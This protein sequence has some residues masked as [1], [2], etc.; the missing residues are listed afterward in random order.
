MFLV[1]LIA[2]IFLAVGK[3]IQ[4]VKWRRKT[5]KIFSKLPGPIERHWLWG[6]YGNMPEDQ[7][8]RCDA[9]IDMCRTHSKETGFMRV[10]GILWTPIIVCCHPSSVRQILRSSEPKPMN[11]TAGYKT[12]MDWLGPG[13][14][15]TNG[16][17]WARKRRLLTKNFH[18]TN[19]KTYVTSCNESATEYLTKLSMFADQKQEFDVYLH[20]KLCML[21]IVL[22]SLV[23]CKKNVQF[24]EQG[25][26][27]VQKV[28]ELTE[29][30]ATR[31]RT[32]LI[33][34]SFLFYQ[35]EMGHTFKR[36][37]E[38]LH[39]FSESIIEERLADYERRSP[40]FDGNTPD[41]LDTLLT[42]RDENGARLPLLDIRHEVD[43]L[44]IG[45]DTTSTS[46]SWIL[47]MLAEHPEIQERCR[48]EL[49]NVLGDRDEVEWADLPNLEYLTMCIKEGL[50]L[51]PTIPFVA[52][53]TTKDF[54][55][56][57]VTVPA[58][59]MIAI[60]IWMLHHNENVWGPDHWEFKPERFSKENCSTMD[61][62]TFVP[63][64]AGP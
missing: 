39:A 27:Y 57:G 30:N 7:N 1:L 19:I 54:E 4:F 22:R 25:K 32:P 36:N 14:L 23:S 41:V 15:L 9:L 16:D 17:I 59:T 61:P 13:L 40:D 42:A 38:F 21:D 18:P 12:L 47:Y 3:L 33:I 34:P 20:N 55:V 37:Y 64:A 5:D 49:N 8:A 28:R 10:W 58:K 56:G 29:I 11:I 60:N 53:E 46:C 31:L 63:F 48:R 2:G 52:R 35:T 51:Y 50:R 44:I 45:F 43:G 24:S 26:L 62:Y 6:S